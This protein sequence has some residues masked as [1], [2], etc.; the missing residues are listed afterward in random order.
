MD[1][2]GR[3]LATATV[4]FCMT[5]AGRA[6]AGPPPEVRIFDHGRQ[7]MVPGHL[8][9]AGRLQHTVTLA[10]P[11]QIHDGIRHAEYDMVSSGGRKFAAIHHREDGRDGTT[12]RI[13]VRDSASGKT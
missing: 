10:R 13:E 6:D 9:V 2:N 5:L 1:F 12:G 3:A 8:F 7:E 4:A 11:I